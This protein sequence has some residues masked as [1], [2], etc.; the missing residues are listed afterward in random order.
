MTESER[1][2]FHKLEQRVIALTLALTTVVRVMTDA[3]LDDEPDD[4]EAKQALLMARAALDATK[5]PR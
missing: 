5:T 2:E 1:E 3:D 4:D